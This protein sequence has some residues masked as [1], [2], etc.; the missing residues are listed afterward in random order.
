MNSALSV[1]ASILKKLP[2]FIASALSSFHSTAMATLESLNF[3]NLALQRL[4]IDPVSDNYVRQVNGA[5]FSRVS[6]TPVKNPKVVAYSSG[7]MALLDLP[8]EEC[9]RG[10]FAKYFSGNVLP[11]GAESAAHCYCGHQFGYFSGQL[12]DGAAMY[13]GEVVNNK[14]E[15][16]EL[17]LKGAGKTPYSRSADGRKVLRSSIREFL[18]SEVMH[19]LGVP[20]T[21][22]GSCVTS[23]SY[24]TRDIFYTGNNIQERCTIISRIAPTFIRFGSFEIFKGT[25]RETGRKGPSNNRPDLLPQLADYVIQTFYPKIWEENSSDL[26]QMYLAFFREVCLRTAR[27]VAKWQCVGFCHGV[28]NTDNMSIVGVTIDYGPYGFLDRYDPDFIC[29]SSDDGGRYAYNKQPEICRWNCGKLAEALQPLLPLSKSAPVLKEY[30]EAFEAEYWGIMRKKF[31]FLREIPNDRELMDGFLETM[32]RTGADFTNCFR[33]LSKLQSAADILAL[34][35]YLLNQ[36]CSAAQYRK[37]FS[38]QMDP[39]QLQM[40]L[41]LQSSNPELLAMLGKKADALQ[42]EMEMIQKAEE[43]KGLTPEKKKESDRKL[44]ME[45]L[46]KYADRVGQ[47][48]PNGNRVQIMNS[49]NPRIVLR[50][51][52]A[53]GAIDA[54]EKGDYSEVRRV[55]RAFQDPFDESI[56]YSDF[57]AFDEAVEG[58]EANVTNVDDDAKSDNP[59]CSR[60][61]KKCRIEYDARPPEESI[62][63]VS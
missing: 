39:T 32:Y 7:A 29:N 4:P 41:L 27:L 48:D 33:I 43:L 10:D 38:P 22:S 56:R 34:L 50:N 57:T 53:Q 13:L 11:P 52:I 44:W 24:V 36:C 31:G 17:Q 2:K 58:P 49:T 25:D 46:G 35:E 30:D 19:N 1:R 63:R 61:P 45:W 21:R 23:D 12:G 9:R 6:P 14:G 37:A 54:A 20:T 5:C 55:L 28:L 3:D 26:E 47:E 8:D 40:L 59:S 15:R 16:W 62:I 42:R 18:C 51:F 60:P